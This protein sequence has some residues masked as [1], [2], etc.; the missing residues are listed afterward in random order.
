[1][2][3]RFSSLSLLLSYSYLLLKK[4]AAAKT[5]DLGWRDSRAQCGRIYHSRFILTRINITSY[6]S[7]IWQGIPAYIRQDQREL[8]AVDSWRQ[9]NSQQVPSAHAMVEIA[10]QL[11]GQPW[12][13][14]SEE[15]RSMPR[16]SSLRCDFKLYHCQI[17]FLQ[18]SPPEQVN[19]SFK[20]A[21]QPQILS[22]PPIRVDIFQ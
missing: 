22:T 14:E 6:T 12:K 11:P 5:D 7:L 10:S 15:Q 19:G 9:D 2:L 18:C 8:A 4:Y 20:A 13:Y 16:P 21:P 17:I 3:L 1:M